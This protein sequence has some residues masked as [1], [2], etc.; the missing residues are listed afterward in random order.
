MKKNQKIAVGVGVA[1]LLYFL[2]MKSKKKNDV[3]KT[4]TID[5]IIK[6]RPTKK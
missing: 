2:W 3:V 6:V 4:S 5:E 1:I